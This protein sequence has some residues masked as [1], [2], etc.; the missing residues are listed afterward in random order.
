MKFKHFQYG[1]E[2]PYRKSI[3]YLISAMA[4][5]KDRVLEKHLMPLDIT[6]AQFK[7]FISM[8]YGK[9]ET[10]AEFCRELGLD[11]GAMTRMLDR[12]EKKGLIERRRCPTD[13]RVVRVDLTEEGHKVADRIPNMA[14]DALNELFEPISP[15]E[16]ASL[17]RIL[18]KIVNA[19]GQSNPPFGTREED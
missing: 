3:G 2:F 17:E 10:P 5:I 4:H 7:V 9:M 8:V 15:E 18:W 14:V 6:P 1:E 19:A 13:R 11:S 12:L 16:F